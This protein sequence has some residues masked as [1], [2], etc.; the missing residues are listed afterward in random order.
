MTINKVIQETRDI[1]TFQLVFQDEAMREKFSFKA[2]QFAE[3]SAFGS[4]EST[5]CI[6][7][8]PTRKDHIEC[9]FRKVG[10]N[11]AGLFSLSEGDTMGFRGPYGNVFPLEKLKG[12]NLMFIGGG[13]ALPPLRSLIWNVLD[14][15]DQFGDVSIVYGARSVEDLVYK[16]EIEDWESRSDVTLVKTVD[17]GGETPQWD[18]HVG[19]VPTVLEKEFAPRPD[20]TIA[21]VCGPPIMIKFTFEALDRLGFKPE[22]MITTL[23]N[24]MK[25]GLGKCGR[26]NIGSTYV[27]LDGPVFWAKE[28]AELPQEF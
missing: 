21:I 26:C 28:L 27:C 14:L 16:R 25:C 10:K 6:A 7:S 11:T 13:I 24:R 3:Y 12:K 22:Q 19:F 20:N 18:G 17:P 5:F 9:C 1:K 2:G 15:R 23:E 4:G 8:S